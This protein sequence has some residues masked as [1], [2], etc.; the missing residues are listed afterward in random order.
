MFG[1]ILNYNDIHST[2][3]GDNHVLRM[4]TQTYILKA[5]KR[6]SEGS[7]LPPTL[8]YLSLS[9]FERPTFSGSLTST[10]QLLFL[11]K[12]VASYLAIKAATKLST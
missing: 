7:E 11:F 2:W 6:A 8:E 10:T 4:Q 3:E 1:D 5:M 12:Q 9:Q